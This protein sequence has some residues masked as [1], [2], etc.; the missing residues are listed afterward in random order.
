EDAGDDREHDLS[1]MPQ[2]DG[3]RLHPRQLIWRAACQFLGRGETRA[4]QV[5]GLSAAGLRQGGEEKDDRDLDVPLHGLRLSGIL[6][7]QLA[8]QPNTFFGTSTSPFMIGR[9]VRKVPATTSISW[10]L[11]LVSS[12]T[13]TWP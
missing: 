7:P 9:A 11:P 10:P 12:R 6:R 2:R 4:Q 5:P 13:S 1:E 3:S 8:A